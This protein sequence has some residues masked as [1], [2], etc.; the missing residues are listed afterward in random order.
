MAG[1]LLSVKVQLHETVDYTFPQTHSEIRAEK[2]VLVGALLNLHHKPLQPGVTK[3]SLGTAF[4]TTKPEK[5]TAIQIEPLRFSS[6][7]SQEFI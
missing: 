4:S 3:I 2:V 7:Y 5:N 6:S 1:F